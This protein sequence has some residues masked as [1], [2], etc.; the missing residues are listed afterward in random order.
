MS[1]FI[2]IG[3]I[4]VER[5]M[6]RWKSA[7]RCS[8]TALALTWVAAASTTEASELVYQPI[9]PSFGGNP[10][11][12]DHLLGLADRQNTHNGSGSSSGGSTAAISALS[13][14]QQFANQL[15]SRMM[16]AL[17]ANITEAMFGENAQAAGEV[18]FGSQTISWTNDGTNIALT[19]FDSSTGGTTTIQVPTLSLVAQ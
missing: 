4:A 2:T 8:V 18:V 1:R 9:N 16:S 15:Q 13:Q 5:P 6:R 19:I 3:P 7:W 12:S 10:F 11:N 14:G 17:S